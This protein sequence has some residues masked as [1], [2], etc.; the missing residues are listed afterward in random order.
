[1]RVIA[2]DAVFALRYLA[3][4]R[5]FTALATLTIAMGVGGTAAMYRVV[6]GVLVR[7][8]PYAAPGELV[9]IWE[10]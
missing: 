3:R 8:L 6:D 9:S 7:A 4:R 1:M 2:H 5:A 10:T